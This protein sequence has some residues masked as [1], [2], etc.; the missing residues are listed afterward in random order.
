MLFG[1]FWKPFWKP[2]GNLLDALGPPLG[3]FWRTLAALGVA[4]ET[5]VGLGALWANLGRACKVFVEYLA[6][7]FKSFV[8]L[9]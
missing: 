1:S 5:F 4:F 6:R 8:I 7:F 3:D 2:F 9:S